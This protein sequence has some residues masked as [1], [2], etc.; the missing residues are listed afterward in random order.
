M[1]QDEVPSR[2]AHGSRGFAALRIGVFVTSLPKMGA[3][4]CQVRPVTLITA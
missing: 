1:A 3:F 2:T 4:L